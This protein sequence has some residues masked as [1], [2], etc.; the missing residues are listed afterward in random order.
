MKQISFFKFSNM[1]RI[2][3]KWMFC[4]L[5]GCAELIRLGVAIRLINK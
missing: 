1:F 4:F 5:S 3:K 2:T